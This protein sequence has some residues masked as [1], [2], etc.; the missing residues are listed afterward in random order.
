[1]PLAT[2][3]QKTQPQLSRQR[4]RR[5]E[6]GLHKLV[7]RGVCSFCGRP[8]ESNS[9]TAGGFDAQG[10]VVIA[11]ECCA[12]RV[13][14]IFA[15][16]LEFTGE[17]VAAA[18]I[19]DAARRGGIDVPFRPEWAEH[20]WKTDDSNWF[21]RNPQRSHR[22]RMLF[23]GEAREEGVAETEAERTLIVLVRQIEPGVRAR[24]ILSIPADMPLPDDKAFAHA[25]FE[26]AIGREP[27][28]RKP[29]VLCDLIEKYTAR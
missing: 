9:P 22:V 19:D 21:E 4:R 10:N 23:P 20:P 15:V 29:Q 3:T 1:M 5:L 7:P 24:G 6:R 16:G 17:H 14:E 13:A 8:F 11:G 26:I 12:S 28:P 27:M 25:M 2:S 18:R